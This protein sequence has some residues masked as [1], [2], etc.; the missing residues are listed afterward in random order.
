M[1]I[2]GPTRPPAAMEKMSQLEDLLAT[3]HQNVE[4]SRQLL[5]GFEPTAIEIAEAFDEILERAA[6]EF[7]PRETKVA[8]AESLIIEWSSQIGVAPSEA[9]K[10]LEFGT[11]V[12]NP[13]AN[14]NSKQTQ[15]ALIEALAS[16]SRSILLLRLRRDYLFGLTD[17]LRGRVT[18][19]AGY[20][21]LQAESVAILFACQNSPAIG[22][23]W[24]RTQDDSEGREFYKTHHQTL[25][26][27]LTRFDLRNDYD[28][29]SASAL[30]SRVGGV[31]RGIVKA[32]MDDPGGRQIGLVYQEHL[33][34]ERYF[35][36]YCHYLRFHEKV[37]RLIEDLFPEVASSRELSLA[38]LSYSRQL[39]SMWA[40]M[41][42]VYRARHPTKEIS[43][44]LWLP[45]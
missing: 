45:S 23:Q 17:L 36:A 13:G 31:A 41:K 4:A 18:M 19:S 12:G 26:G 8:A 43:S 25:L 3:D 14:D 7:G 27:I 29:A 9:M 11:L 2:W 15:E 30:H 33:E 35:L 21:R 44:T 6:E 22:A 39:D 10:L 38:I 37:A 28:R 42:S 32:T 40:K 24:L 16:A 20:L 1:T 5:L 34:P